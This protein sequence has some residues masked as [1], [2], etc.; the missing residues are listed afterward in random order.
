LAK[1]RINVSGVYEVQHLSTAIGL[2]AA[3]VGTA[4]LP[5]STI[6]EGGS[7]GVVRIPLVRPVVKRGIALIKRKWATLSPAADVFYG[8]LDAELVRKSQAIERTL[9]I[10]HLAQRDPAILL[11]SSKVQDDTMKLT[12]IDAFSLRLDG[13][14]SVAVGPRHCVTADIR[15]F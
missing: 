4:M 12:P 2:V 10:E 11:T 9:G 1:R 14:L 3:G 7:P 8:M 13:L 15:I 5:F 6:Q